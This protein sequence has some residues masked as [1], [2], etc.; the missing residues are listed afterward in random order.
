MQVVYAILFESAKILS[1]LLI[2]LAFIISGLI[3]FQ[4]ALVIRWNHWLNTHFCTKKVQQQMDLTVDTTEVVL[5]YRWLIGILFLLGALFTGKFMFLDFHP[6]KF[7]QLVI[8][9]ASA[10]ASMFYGILFAALKWLFVF[11]SA[12]GAI[13]CFVLMF[14]PELFRKISH[15]LDKAVSTEHVGTMLDTSHT[16]LDNWVFKHHIAVGLFMF[17]AS[18]YLVIMFLFVYR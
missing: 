3:L 7:V 2:I 16:F 5:Q 15:K 9:P 10:T 11:C 14:Q 1:Y 12:M 13:I 4:P 6:E 17:L 18:S 8:N